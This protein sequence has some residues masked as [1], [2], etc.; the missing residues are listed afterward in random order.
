MSQGGLDRTWFPHSGLTGVSG[1]CNGGWGVDIDNFHILHPP[2]SSNITFAYVYAATYVHSPGDRLVDLAFGVDDA[3]RVYLNG[4]LVYQGNTCDCADT[5]EIVVEDLTLNEGQNVLLMQVANLTAEAGFVARFLHPDDGTAIQDI[6]TTL[7]PAGT[8]ACQP[9]A[10]LPE[11]P[12][13]GLDDDCSG[14]PLDQERDLDGDGQWE[15]MGDCAPL[16]NSVY[17][18]APETCD[19]RDQDCDGLID[20]GLNVGEACENVDDTDICLD[21]VILCDDA[22][23]GA[24]CSGGAGALLTF[25][26][27]ARMGLD[28]SGTGD[29]I[30]DGPAHSSAFF[31]NGLG[32]ALFAGSADAVRIPRANAESPEFT[33]AAWVNPSVAGPRA[34]VSTL[35]GAANGLLVG[36]QDWLHFQGVV[37]P[38]LPAL[39][40]GVWTHVAVTYDRRVLRVYHDGALVSGPHTIASPD[41]N[42]AFGRA[43]TLDSDVWVGAELDHVP[44]EVRPGCPTG[45]T[46]DPNQNFLGAMDDVAWYRH[47]LSQL[48]IQALMVAIPDVDRNLELC[49]A[50]D[51]DCDGAFD[52][53]FL[54][55][56]P[57]DGADNDACEDA[58]TV[59]APGG[60]TTECAFGSA[61]LLSFDTLQT[62]AGQQRATDLSGNGNDAILGPDATSES[63]GG[64]TGLALSAQN[65]SYA[66]ADLDEAAR[67]TFT[68]S[69]LVRSPNTAMGGRFIAHRMTAF[70]QTSGCAGGGFSLTDNGVLQFQCQRFRVPAFAT[71]LHLPSRP[72]VAVTVVYDGRNLQA[73]VGGVLAEIERF[74]GLF[75]V[76][77]GTTVSMA[78][79]PQITWV[80]DLVLGQRMIVP[81]G[82]FSN[83][84]AWE[85]WLD[86]VAWFDHVPEPAVLTP[87]TT[88]VFPEAIVNYELCDGE[89]N[90]CRDGADEIHTELG[91]A[92]S[93]GA[94]GCIDAGVLVCAESGIGT[95]CSTDGS[96]PQEEVCDAIDNDCDGV[97][98]NFTQFCATTCG[99]G[100]QLCTAGVW[101]DCDVTPEPELCDGLDNDCD[102]SLDDDGEAEPN[103]GLPCD[104]PDS[105]LCANG[106][107]ECDGVNGM[108]CGAESVENIIEICNGADDDC[109]GAIDEDFPTLGDACTVGIGGCG[110]DGF[111]VCAADGSGPECDATPGLPSPEVCGDGI[112][113]DCDGE[114][115]EGSLDATLEVLEVAIGSTTFDYS[116]C[117][118][119]EGDVPQCAAVV[120]RVT[121]NS[122]TPVPDS[123][124]V[125]ITADDG[126]T[127]TVVSTGGT[128]GRTVAAGPGTEEEFVFCWQNVDALSDVTLEVA[129]NGS[130]VNVTGDSPETV[131]LGLCS[132]TEL[133]D[134]I[135]NNIDGRV[136]EMPEACGGDPTL[137]CLNDEVFD[138]WICTR[139]LEGE[140]C[141]DSGCPIGEFC[142][143]GVCT[144]GCSTDSHCPSGTVC[145]DGSCADASAAPETDAQ[146]VGV[147]E[148]TGDA[149]RDDASGSGCAAA[150]AGGASLW[151]CFGLLALRRRRRIG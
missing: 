143:D 14:A 63:V 149:P 138:N 141:E 142:S 78:T 106:A 17:L 24:Y 123:A 71:D 57:C 38:A 33:F 114:T 56:A 62:A 140:S 103:Y 97:A 150:A 48:D 87:L 43:H 113:N 148:G 15:C 55:A 65:T 119:F 115:D 128:L 122:A 28:V 139:G 12:C 26:A 130:C 1:A 19:Y 31:R 81:N 83:T 16:D 145:V 22:T 68:F 2:F 39:A 134:A 9:G 13:N 120:F 95:A 104:G 96:E 40:P 85:G 44:S 147:L 41:P 151:W 73:Y 49:D 98:D 102:L 101:S 117:E 3:A 75:W 66:I 27:P 118:S 59:C 116:R 109:D 69:A 136:N 30:V 121:N 100:Q 29:A 90:N 86:Q 111:L 124:G 6:R 126:T 52:E 20:D 89:D 146:D 58:L 77:E 42:S 108:V 91:T 137:V 47:P 64:R 105:D 46:I 5:D 129:L 54:L 135:D 88:G 61:T 60:V 84:Y 92:C 80:S 34:I 94:G 23:P 112:D 35:D 144:E 93:G 70:E 7:E 82:G 8:I 127:Q 25:E 21:G 76:D 36:T 74:T 79:V 110:A 45:C 37:Y 18:G 99:I 132:E 50:R 32:G 133:C 125:E 67:S 11:I 51:N 107:W 10:P 4:A 72:W 131:D 53:D